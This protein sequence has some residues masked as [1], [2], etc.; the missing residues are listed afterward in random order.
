MLENWQKKVLDWGL[1]DYEAWGDNAVAKKVYPDFEKAFFGFNKIIIKKIRNK[2]NEIVGIQEVP[3]F[4]K[5][6]FEKVLGRMLKQYE[7][8]NGEF[9]DGLTDDQKVN[10]ITSQ[11]NYKNRKARDLITKMEKLEK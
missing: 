4:F 10:I 2:K 8:E 11:L 7:N 5:G 3:I 9:E 1:K 6:K